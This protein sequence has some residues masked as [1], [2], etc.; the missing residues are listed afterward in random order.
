[1]VRAPVE[2]ESPGVVQTPGRKRAQETDGLGMEPLAGLLIKCPT[3]SDRAVK[4]ALR[5]PAAALDCPRRF[6]KRQLC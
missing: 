5:R 4:G 1:M 6:G 3:R 2:R